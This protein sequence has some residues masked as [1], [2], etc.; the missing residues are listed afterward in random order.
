MTGIG[1]GAILANMRGR[2]PVKEYAP[3]DRPLD[4]RFRCPSC[5][6]IAAHHPTIDCDVETPQDV[7]DA[8]A[9]FHKLQHIH[10]ACWTEVHDVLTFDYRPM[11]AQEV[12]CECGMMLNRIIHNGREIP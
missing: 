2:T 3:E 10:S 5:G 9:A 4:P 11:Q 1:L 12:W 7:V 6:R 8:A